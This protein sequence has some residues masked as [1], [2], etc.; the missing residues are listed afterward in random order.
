M[1]AL[2]PRSLAPAGGTQ[3]YVDSWCQNRA[4]RC[5]DLYALGREEVAITYTVTVAARRQWATLQIKVAGPT[6]ECFGSTRN[7]KNGAQPRQEDLNSKP[8]FKN[9]I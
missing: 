8:N 6:K 5:I 1:V 3:Q 7:V 2:Q 9:S 4:R